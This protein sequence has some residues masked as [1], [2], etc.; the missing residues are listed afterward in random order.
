MASGT[1]LAI[2]A[3]DDS[4]DDLELLGRQLEEIEGYDIALRNVGSIDAAWTHLQKHDID[5][6]LIDYRLDAEDGLSLVHQFRAEGR[7]EAVIVLTGGGDEYIAASISRAGADDYLRKD[8]CTPSM[9]RRA[10]ANATARAQLRAAE[11]RLRRLAQVETANQELAS[12]ATVLSHDLQAP[13]RTLEYYISRAR[14]TIDPA[15]DAG[16]HLDGALGAA[17]RMQLLTRDLL[18]YCKIGKLCHLHAGVRLDVVAAEALENLR[19]AIE[20]QGPDVEIR[21]DL[22]ALPAVSGVRTLL[23]QLF[24]NLIGNALKFRRSEQSPKVRITGTAGRDA[25][26]V[27]IEDNGI[28]I[29]PAAA[30]HVFSLFRRLPA[31]EGVEGSGV[32]LAIARRIV[33][34]HG[35][36]IRVVPSPPPGATLVFTLPIALDEPTS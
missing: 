7:T 25:L 36:E 9:L 15:T 32:G 5:V 8:H 29:D 18:D 11:S 26:E 4:E 13:L 12:F 34:Q 24:Q 6:L 22:G 2:L 21:V 20:A 3:V 14:T 10:I 17:Q 35:G 19:G 23:V 30:Q 1:K 16:K 28:G 33:E 27:R 31:A